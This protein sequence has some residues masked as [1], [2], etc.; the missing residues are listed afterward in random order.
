L[1]PGEM[2]QFIESVAA[3]INIGRPTLE[4]EIHDILI[5]RI[6]NSTFEG[7]H[8]PY[9]LVPEENVTIERNKT[10]RLVYLDGKFYRIVSPDFILEDMIIE[11]KMTHDGHYYDQNAK[12][13]LIQYLYTP[14]IK[15]VFMVLSGSYRFIFM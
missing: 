12:R 5:G 10:G 4:S 3:N 8:E 1:T 13:Q 14:G 11:I 9:T 2:Q 7:Y 15:A 6:N